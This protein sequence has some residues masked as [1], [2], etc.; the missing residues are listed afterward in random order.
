MW[1]QVL[2]GGKRITAIGSSDSHRPANK[3]GL[4]TTHVQTS[5]VTEQSLL[6]AIRRGRVYVTRDAQ[7]SRLTFETE[8]V[9]SETKMRRGIGGDIQL[10]SNNGTIRQFKQNENKLEQIIELECKNDSCFRTE[11]RDEASRMLAFTNPIYVTTKTSRT[12]LAAQQP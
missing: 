3:I 2:R 8:P 1:D 6:E 4:P 11:V 12:P 9:D 7:G 10:I 5:A